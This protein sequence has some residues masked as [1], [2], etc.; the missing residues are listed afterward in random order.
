MFS[1]DDFRYMQEAMAL[2]QKGLL[3]TTP[4][5]RVGAVFVKNEAIIGRGFTQPPGNAHAEVMALLDCRS[6]GEDPRGS[7]VYVTLEPCSHFGRTPPCAAALIEAGVSRVVAAMEDPNPMVAGHG[8]EALRNAGIEVRVGLL[9]NEARNLNLGFVSRM[10]RKRPWVRLKSAASVDGR[11]ALEN[12]ESQW[13]TGAEARRDGHMFRARACA[14]LTGIGTV[15]S[16][17]PMLNVRDVETPRQPSRFVLDSRLEIDLESRIVRSAAGG[18]PVT[19]FTVRGEPVKS[20]ELTARGCEVVALPDADGKVD[21]AA[22]MMELGTRQINE[23]HVEA[24]AKLNAS[25]LRSGLV[26]EMLIYMAPCLLGPGEGI[27]EL[28][29][30]SSLEQ[31]IPMRFTDIE[32]I[33]PDL[34]ILAQLGDLAWTKEK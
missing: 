22:L 31:R 1:A 23:L 19:I 21:L 11:S 33:G 34:R 5:P 14:I 20:A 4:N 29:A 18:S 8:F 16:D 9:E 30:L 26:D 6:H 25:L 2:A 3:T 32:Q 27:A 13:I 7:T 28:P 17:N 15:R 12:G 24:G 10:I